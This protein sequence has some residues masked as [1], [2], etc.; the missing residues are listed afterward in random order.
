MKVKELIKLALKKLEVINKEQMP[1]SPIRIA[2]LILAN[3]IK[4]K[5]ASLLATMQDKTLSPKEQ[6][7]FFQ[8]LQSFIDGVPFEYI[9]GKASFY[10]RDFLVL[11]G[12][13][14]PRSETELLVEKV[15][16]LLQ[17][18]K[19][20]ICE[21]GTGSGVISIMLSLLLPDAKIVATDI[22][23]IAIKNATLNAEKFNKK[24][25][26]IQTNLMDNIQADFDII[27]SNPPYIANAYK[28]D[29]WVLSE[30]H[31]A[32]FGGENGDEI[33]KKIIK[34]AAT[35]K[36]KF[37]ACEMGYDQRQSLEEYLNAHGYKADFYKDLAGF[38]RGFIARLK[39]KI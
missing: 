30:P 35:K 16:N 11:K 13:L 26:F 20:K 12:V 1:S 5:E 33:L 36:I 6:D 21:I 4:L 14:I 28:L 31:E 24:I 2:N 39:E 3:T 23:P 29:K 27:V 22:N 7:N 38:D 10:S 8:D 25:D 15:A 34:L 32:L 17:N 19:A 18:K 9:S 37:I